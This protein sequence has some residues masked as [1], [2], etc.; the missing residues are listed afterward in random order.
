MPEKVQFDYDHL[1]E[2]I[3]KFLMPWIGKFMYSIETPHRICITVLSAFAVIF[4]TLYIRMCSISIL[5]ICEP[6]EYIQAPQRLRNIIAYIQRGIVRSF[7][8]TNNIS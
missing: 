5:Y 4:H 3:Q 6:N 2:I 1:R 8:V 7:D